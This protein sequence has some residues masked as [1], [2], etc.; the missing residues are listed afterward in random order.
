V[1]KMVAKVNRRVNVSSVKDD[2]ALAW[3]LHKTSF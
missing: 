1:S 2:L 3:M